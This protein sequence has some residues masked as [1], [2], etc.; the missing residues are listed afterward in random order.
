MWI[1]NNLTIWKDAAMDSLRNPWDSLQH[2]LYSYF[3]GPSRESQTHSVKKGSV[4][5]A[6][7]PREIT[8]QPSALPLNHP[9][10]LNVGLRTTYGLFNDVSLNTQLTQPQKLKRLWMINWKG[11]L[12]IYIKALLQHLL[13]GT[14]KSR[15]T[16][17]NIDIFRFL[18]YRRAGDYPNTWKD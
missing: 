2:K 13:G 5:A 16:S 11:T 14:E 8:I 9:T 7:N 3:N 1:R 17:V 10:R 15:E 12:K 4:M 6:S 18:A